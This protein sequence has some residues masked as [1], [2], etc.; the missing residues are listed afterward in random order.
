MLNIQIA[1]W[2]SAV[3]IL[4]GYSVSAKLDYSR[5]YL[6][7]LVDYADGVCSKAR[8]ACR[9]RLQASDFPIP[10]IILQKLSFLPTFLFGKA[11][12]VNTVSST[13]L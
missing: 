2:T 11:T 12:N 4:I 13:I 10:K 5:Y 7:V 6:S 3:T 9:R 1:R 8:A